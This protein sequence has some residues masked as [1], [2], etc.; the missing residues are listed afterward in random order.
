M[1]CLLQRSIVSVFL[2][3]LLSLPQLSMASTVEETPSALAMT[4]DLLIAR[5]LLMVITVVST[6]VFVVALPFSALGG[7][8]QESAKTLVAEPFQATFI[9]CLG[10]T[11]AGYKKQLVTNSSAK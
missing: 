4:G 3:L 6:A 9:R 2:G 7:N 11:M 8:T 1:K 5:P 10:C